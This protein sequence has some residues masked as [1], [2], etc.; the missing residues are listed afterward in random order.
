MPSPKSKVFQLNFAPHLQDISVIRIRGS[1]VLPLLVL[2]PVLLVPSPRIP[3]WLTSVCLR[4]EG[5]IG[6][7]PPDLQLICK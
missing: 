2:P 4:P 5:S 7:S 6:V 1:L 3:L